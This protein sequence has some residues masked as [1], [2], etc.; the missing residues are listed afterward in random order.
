ME[1]SAKVIGED[2]P[3]KQL[4]PMHERRVNSQRYKKLLSSIRTVGLVEPLRVHKEGNEKYLIL[5]GYLR[6]KACLELGIETV[7]CILAKEKDAYTT[8]RM[9]NHL[10]PVQ[11]H[12][13]LTKSLEV[14]A[15]DAIAECFGLT[16][17]RH[18][19][20]KN[21][22]DQLHPDVIEAFDK[23]RISKVCVE[24]MTHVIPER[25]ATILKELKRAGEY[26]PPFIRTLILRTPPA[27]RNTAGKK[28]R[29]WE[30][31]AQHKKQLA[32]KLAETEN[33]YDLYTMLYQQYTMDLM[34]M[35]FYIRKLITNEK[36]S[37]FLKKNHPE[38]LQGFH[39]FVFEWEGGKSKKNAMLA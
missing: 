39:T 20:Q 25:Q 11:E 23:N 17:I 18:R 29:L 5:E 32:A 4:V 1:R 14:L 8:N 30:R 22:L 34:R 13:M 12:R 15:E 2:I 3:V 19:I 35:S 10:S 9:I 33:R 26:S 16:T 7:P 36:V 38:I 37:A 6:Y 21:L 28:A 27:L 24:E 31:G